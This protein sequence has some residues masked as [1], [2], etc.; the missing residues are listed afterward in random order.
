MDGGSQQKDKEEDSENLVRSRTTTSRA[1]AAAAGLPQQ[2]VLER[3]S[4]GGRPAPPL[5]P[6]LAPLQPTGKRPVGRGAGGPCCCGPGSDLH[7]LPRR[8]HGLNV[9]VHV[10]GHACTD[11]HMHT[12]TLMRSCVRAL[13]CTN[14]VH[15]LNCVP[16]QDSLTFF[17]LHRTK[18][19]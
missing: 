4:G 7:A 3:G 12:H 15:L 8:C 9:Q 17:V 16:E 2:E 13:M 14:V 5:P 6:H 10:H 19:K 11:I 18:C 1:D